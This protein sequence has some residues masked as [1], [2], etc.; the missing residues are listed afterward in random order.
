[1]PGEHLQIGSTG[2]E[3]DE[4]E[5]YF[6]PKVDLRTARVIGMEA[7]ARWAHPSLGLLPAERFIDLVE[8]SGR[9]PALT[10]RVIQIAARAAGDWWRSGLGMQ[11]SVNLAP[12]LFSATDWKLDQLVSG[13]LARTGLPGKALQF[14]ITEDALVARPD[15]AAKTLEKL[16]GL[17]ATVSV[18]DF[19]TGHFS[20]KQLMELPITELKID[21]SL[22]ADLADNQSKTIIRSTIHFAHQVGLQV[23]AEG[24]ETE[25]AWRQLRSL[26]CERAQGFLIAKPLPSREVP[27]WLASWN[28]RARALSSTG[29]TKRLGRAAKKIA[30]KPA[31]APA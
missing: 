1:M 9:M 17:G 25:Q 20:F 26:G 16:S 31:N 7:L 14:E 30:G 23:V 18:D 2:P 4:L 22:V 13:T 19:G 24:V 3:S 12:S 21:R 11:L 10:E 28:Q 5:V 6:Q 15:A 27:A 8:S 29:H